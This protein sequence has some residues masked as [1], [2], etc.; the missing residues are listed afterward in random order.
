M[1]V[2]KVERRLCELKNMFTE[3]VS[4]GQWVWGMKGCGRKPAFCQSSGAVVLELYC[5]KAERK[6]E[7]KER[8]RLAMAMCREGGME[9]EKES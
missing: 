2:I 8:E 1:C 6:R 9:G 7:D 5:R 4:V 3:W